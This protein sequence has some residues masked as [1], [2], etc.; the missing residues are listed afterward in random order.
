[1]PEPPVP[2][3]MCHH[4]PQ[5]EHDG[6]FKPRQCHD[7]HCWCVHE[8]GTEIEG[9]RKPLL[10]R[11]ESAEEDD[12]QRH[13]EKNKTIGARI[14]FHMRHNLDNVDKHME[15]IKKLVHEHM[16]RWMTI[17]REAIIQVNVRTHEVHIIQ[18]EVVVMHTGHFDLSSALMHFHEHFEKQNLNVEVEPGKKLEPVPR[19]VN[20]DRQFEHRGVTSCWGRFKSFYHHYPVAVISG[21]VAAGLLLIL[22]FM[23]TI[24]VCCCKTNR[25]RQRYEVKNYDKNL[26][27]ANQLY[28]YPEVVT[29]DEKAILED[30]KEE[31]AL[32]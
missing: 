22:T 30:K 11:A 14:Q 25:G 5:C 27:F 17:E 13:C 24:M 4:E 26:S 10:V 31:E 1:M 18:I 6:T 15:Q 8:N 2:G 12:N 16:A 32:A 20:I 21:V 29:G 19:T 28:N 23:A 3:M 9:T 7:K